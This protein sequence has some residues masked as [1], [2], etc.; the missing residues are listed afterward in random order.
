MRIPWLTCKISG[1]ETPEF[2]PKVAAAALGL[3]HDFIAAKLGVH[4][5]GYSRWMNGAR[6]IPTAYHTKLAR[7]LK[8]RRKQIADFSAKAKR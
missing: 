2:S 3:R 8:V 5:T 1:M 6:P 7:I 4:P